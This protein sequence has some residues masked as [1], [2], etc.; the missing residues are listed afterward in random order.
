MRV[1]MRD[2][3]RELEQESKFEIVKQDYKRLFEEISEMLKAKNLSMEILK[4]ISKWIKSLDE[5][6]DEIRSYIDRNNNNKSEI[7]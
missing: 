5:I 3:K 6:G 4:D 7:Y 1:Q 2:T